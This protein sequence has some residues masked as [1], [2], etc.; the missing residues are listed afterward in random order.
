MVMKNKKKYEQR[1]KLKEKFKIQINKY[2]SL[3][4]KKLS[5]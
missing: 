2:N 3:S 4:N 5:L 1:E